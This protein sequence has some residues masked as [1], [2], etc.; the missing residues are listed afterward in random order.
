M[1]ILEAMAQDNVVIS[2]DG[3][4][5]PDS[6]IKNGKNGYLVAH[7]DT[8]QLAKRIDLTMHNDDELQHILQEGHETLQSYSA[9]AVYHDFMNMFN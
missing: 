7:D 6:I 5:G 8:S 4:T 3:N 1:V 2:F 9:E